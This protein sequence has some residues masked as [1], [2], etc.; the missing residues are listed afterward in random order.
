MN[1]STQFENYDYGLDSSWKDWI[2][3]ESCRRLDLRSSYA[4][5]FE[6]TQRLIKNRLCVIFQT[7]SLLVYF[8]PA[9]LCDSHPDLIFAPLPAKKQLWE[10][11]DKYSWKAENDRDCGVFDCF[12]L[13]TNGDLVR[14]DE[15]KAYCGDAS[16]LH[17]PLSN[18][19]TAN[20][21]EWCSGMDG[22]GGLVML[23]ASLV[24]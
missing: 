19:T 12:G 10:A 15:G 17:Q 16:M 9:A 2:F 13:A 21:E 23:A 5:S 14:L 1:Y 6:A 18:K 3:E 7:V 24:A 20:W 8:E 4:D 22:L 11:G